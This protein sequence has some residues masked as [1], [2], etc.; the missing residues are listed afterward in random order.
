MTAEFEAD[1]SQLADIMTRLINE[2]IRMW[3]FN[4]KEPTLEDVFMLVTKGLV[5]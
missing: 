1:D 5:T 4:D 2:G 3:T